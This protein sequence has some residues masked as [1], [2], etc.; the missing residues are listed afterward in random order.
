MEHCS[1]SNSNQK[2]LE[3]TTGKTI[4]LTTRDSSILTFPLHYYKDGCKQNKGPHLDLK[5]LIKNFWIF[6]DEIR[7]E[8]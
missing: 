8:G 3:G 4:R 7:I 5:D 6:M 2:L 1:R